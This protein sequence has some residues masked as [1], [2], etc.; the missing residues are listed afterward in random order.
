M[1]FVIKHI[2]IS[3][4][5]CFENLETDFW[6]R[7][8]V[9]SDNEGGKSSLASAILWALT[10][11]DSDGNS[12][13]EIVPSGKYGKVSP[14][15]EL[16]C[17]V[18]DKP[19][20][21]K[22]EYK[23]KY[24][25]DKSFKDYA[26][27][28]Y[29]NG[30]E[31]GARKF[32]EY[33]SQ[34]I[35]NENVFKILSNPYTFIE[36]C[37][38][39]QKELSW[40]SQ[41]RMLMELV[42]NTDDLD[43]VK[44]DGR[45]GML[46]EPL[47]RYSNANEYL[48]YLKQET[49]KSQKEVNSFESK[50]EQQ[51]SNLLEDVGEKIVVDAEIKSDEKKILELRGKIIEL[52]NSEGTKRK[53]ELLWK[54]RDI[55]SRKSKIKDNYNKLCIEQADQKHALELEANE[56]KSEA[57]EWIAKQSKYAD[58]V[59]QIENTKQSEFCHTCNQRLPV[60]SIKATEEATKKRIEKGKECVEQARKNAETC[61]KAA[62]KRI[63]EAESLHPP[64]FP[65]KEMDALEELANEALQQYK[66]M[67]FTKTDTSELDAKIDALEENI[68]SLK[69]ELY[70]IE[71]NE[72]CKNRIKSLQ[73]EH[74]KNN[75]KLNDFQKA[76]D[77][78][79]DFIYFKCEQMQEKINSLFKTVKFQLFEQNKSNDDIREVCNMTFNGH[80]YEDL[81]ASTKLVANMELLSAFQKHYNVCVP[82]VCDNMESVTADI[83]T[84]AQVISMYVV[85]ER[86]PKC[87]GKSGRRNTDGKW[88]CESCGNRW[89]KEL[90]IKE[91]EK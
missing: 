11:K 34:N 37:P 78:C 20:T 36:S 81:S 82:V 60:A 5:R 64:V 59:S 51:Q 46:E 15:V 39:E 48:S 16:E 40:Q 53:E 30:L 65:A 21:L 3:E 55:E 69:K 13:F 42:S 10:G 70:N 32:Q 72:D 12:A 80:K 54:I 29:I 74:R 73:E 63:D 35:C 62:K 2:K 22:R 7:T 50:M 52:Q 17:M 1:N 49:A 45:W 24:A 67:E 47:K 71:R 6:N 83:V 91:E 14:S 31:V 76:S 75:Q 77:L 19:L 26:T 79:K 38:K 58:A 87:G 57:N 89:E 61:M 41:R 9:Q 84:D 33:I 90:V 85:E 8:V 56:L 25:R 18:D 44:S 66:E 27:T 43:L 28:C 88:T 4:F 68:D 86:C 23:A